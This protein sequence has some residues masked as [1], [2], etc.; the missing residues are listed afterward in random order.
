[1]EVKHL[2]LFANG[3]VLSSKDLS[4]CHLALQMLFFLLN[5]DHMCPGLKNS[6]NIVFQF[7]KNANATALKF[8]VNFSLIFNF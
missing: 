2:D 5:Y 1:M 8:R 6:F 4:K 7:E 3:F